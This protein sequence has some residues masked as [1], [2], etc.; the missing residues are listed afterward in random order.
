MHHRPLLLARVAAA[1]IAV[2]AA[3]SLAAPTTAVASS[4]CGHVRRPPAWRHIVVI[5][6]ENHSYGDILGKRAPKSYFKAL[7]G[8]CG[9]ARAFH[10]VHFPRS[11]PNYL[12]ATGGRRVVTGDC[13]P[14]PGCRSGRGNIFSQLGRPG[15]RLFAESMPSPCYRQ[16]TSLFAARHAPA[17]YYTRIRQATCRA[18]VVPLPSHRLELKRRF[19][20]ITPNLRH[21][22]HDGT[23]AQASAWLKSFLGGTHG[24]LHRRPYTRGHTAVFVWF[25][26]ASSSGSVTTPIPFI[27]I[28][29][30]TPAKRALR[31]MNHFSALRSWES[32]LH[33]PCRGAACFV[34]GLRIPFNL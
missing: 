2:A 17:L 11:L 32:M 21:D 19:T 28:S 3:L 23:P 10:A 25:D 5:A 16:D 18:D 20:W 26:S 24:L 13:T 31:P 33:L 29:P 7:A 14:G 1:G 34:R 15:W 30:S 27:V 4:P 8:K 6:F 12:A 22:M 9:S